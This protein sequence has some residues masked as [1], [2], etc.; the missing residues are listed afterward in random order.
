MGALRQFDR[1][2]PKVAAY[3][4]PYS[5]PCSESGV[6]STPRFLD[7]QPKPRAL[8]THLSG[9]RQRR[10]KER[11]DNLECY[12]LLIETFK[13][14]TVYLDSRYSADKHHGTAERIENDYVNWNSDSEKTARQGLRKNKKNTVLILHPCVVCCDATGGTRTSEVRSNYHLLFSFARLL[15]KC[16]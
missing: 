3:E 2:W 4:F 9:G 12:Y 8:S 13:T 16:T 14:L 15:L 11:L 6:S 10:E 7:E 5:A 1:A